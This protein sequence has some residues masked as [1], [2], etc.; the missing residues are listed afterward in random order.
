MRYA[1]LSFGF[2]LV[3]VVAVAGF[4][5]TP[6]T[7]PP[8]EI[9]SDMDRQPKYHPQAT[10][11]FFPDGRTDR[12]LVPNTVHRGVGYDSQTPLS[13]DAEGRIVASSLPV[14][15]GDNTSYMTG[16]NERGAWVEGFPAPFIVSRATME[17][18]RDRYTIY[19]GVCH[20][21][22][23]DGNGI[24]KTYGMNATPTYHDDRLRTMANGEIFN[25]ITHGKNLMGPYGDKLVPEDRWAVILYVRALQRAQNGRAEDLPAG[26]RKDL[27]L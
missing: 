10:S 21:T 5:G 3:L 16:K 12:P 6:F 27:G 19:C 13:K 2:L 22:L 26:A 4:R 17:R 11:E 24:T 1:Y 7:K 18:G 20:G 23:G 14:F 25:T 9:F 8:F 15:S